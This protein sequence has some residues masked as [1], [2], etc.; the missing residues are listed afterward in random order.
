[1]V[2]KLGHDAVDRLH[3]VGV[4]AKVG[5]VVGHDGGVVDGGVQSQQPWGS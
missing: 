4:A 5:R 1:M 3:V 2:A